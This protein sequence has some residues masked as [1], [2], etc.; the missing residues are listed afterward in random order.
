MAS[1][2]MEQPGTAAQML[3]RQAIFGEQTMR[4][5]TPLGSRELKALP[6]SGL[7]ANVRFLNYILSAGQNQKLSSL[8]GRNAV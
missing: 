3:A 1:L 5:C 6:Q 7:W 2:K 4:K 8:H